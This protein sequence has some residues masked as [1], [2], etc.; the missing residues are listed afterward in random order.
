MQKISKDEASNPGLVSYSKGSDSEDEQDDDDDDEDKLLDWNKLACLL[1]TVYCA[2]LAP[3]ARTTT[4]THSP[5]RSYISSRE[6]YVMEQYE[7]HSVL[8]DMLKVG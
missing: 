5:A 3:L 1:C 8:H 6:L 7:L 2:L 4:L